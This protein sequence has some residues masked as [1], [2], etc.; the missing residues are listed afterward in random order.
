MSDIPIVF[1]RTITEVKGNGLGRLGRHV[2]H[3]PRSWDYPAEI[4]ALKSVVHNSVG[5]P[6]DQTR[7]SCTA[8]ALCGVC[9]SDPNFTKDNLTYTQENAD[10]IYDDEI[11]AEGGNPQTDDPGGT[12][13]TV[14]QVA[15]K[16][17]IISRYHHCFGLNHLIGTLTMRPVMVGVDWYDSFDKPD[18]KGIVSISPNAS[19][20]G[21]HEFTLDEL[22]V[23][24][25]LLG[26]WQSWGDW[27]PL[28]GR[29]YMSFDTM[30]QLLESQGDCT[31]PIV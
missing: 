13:L 10:N 7:G 15:K 19:I 18:S 31:V 29:F 12:G 5:L 30:D 14:C 6:L 28:H 23:T 16:L 4:T 20:R 8:E 17:Q 25:M 27:G 11:V 26:A 21:G 1:K 3:D 22:N 2:A 24:S 9:N